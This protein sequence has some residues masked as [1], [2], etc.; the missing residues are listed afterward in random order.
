MKKF[1]ALLLTL[2]MVLS[3]A[4]CGG[5]KEEA[6]AA[7]AGGDELHLGFNLDTGE[8]AYGPYYDEWS[9][10]TDEELYKQALEEDTTINIYATSSKMLKEE[11]PF[12]ELY[13]GL[14]LVVSD[15]DSDEVLNKAKIE[16]ETGNITA[17]VLQ[18]KDVNGSVFYEYYGQGIVEPFYPK[19]IC[20]N[21][22]E[23]KLK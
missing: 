12:E 10:M 7:N 9:D 14:D 15:L 2:A 1:F 16:N 5:K 6:P 21:I 8:E 13:P 17:D 19:D 3:L 22:D 23:A 18:G 11:E 20:A 4:A